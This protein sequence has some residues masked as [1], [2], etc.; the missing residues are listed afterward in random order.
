MHAEGYAEVD[1]LSDL[2]GD[3]SGLEQMA[4]TSVL[5]MQRDIGVGGKQGRWR[6]PAKTLRLWDK[7]DGDI[8]NFA[9][10][11][12]FGAVFPSE[13]A[14]RV[15][16]SHPGP[17]VHATRISHTHR[18]LLPEA[19]RPSEQGVVE[20]VNT[21]GVVL[22]SQPGFVERVADRALPGVATGDKYQIV[23]D[24]WARKAVGGSSLLRPLAASRFL[25]G[26]LP[27]VFGEW[28]DN[29]GVGLVQALNHDAP[30]LYTYTAGAVGYVRNV[31]SGGARLMVPIATRERWNVDK[32][33]SQFDYFV[34]GAGKDAALVVE[35]TAHRQPRAQCNAKGVL[36]VPTD[37]RAEWGGKQ[38]AIE[39]L[40]MRDHILVTRVGAFASALA[41]AAP[42][43]PPAIRE[44]VTADVFRPR[45][46]ITQATSFFRLYAADKLVRQL[47]PQIYA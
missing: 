13:Y 43:L 33:A 9:L 3:R 19:L 36:T 8:V 32:T 37:I 12:G 40:D 16:F 10:F 2:R 25:Q 21:N 29:P 30:T 41:A 39:L 27:M 7:D 35:P 45:A 23:S 1:F 15:Q 11:N 31:V 42:D 26:A 14:G 5:A 44:L 22:V 24:I 34:A 6:L 17:D 38:K 18:V 4:D 28:P 46:E 47:F 20:C